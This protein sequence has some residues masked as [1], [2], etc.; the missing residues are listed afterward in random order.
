MY[1][2]RLYLVNMNLSFC[3][4]SSGPCHK[5]IV[6]FQDT[7]LPKTA[8]GW[9]SQAGLIYHTLICYER[10]RVTDLDS[11]GFLCYYFDRI[12]SE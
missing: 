10:F 12:F 1:G 7:L 3:F 5:T 11:S 9:N 6:V 4:E 2:E 8:C